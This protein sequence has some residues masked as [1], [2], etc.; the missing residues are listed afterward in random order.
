MPSFP[1]SVHQREGLV[2]VVG[3]ALL[4]EGAGTPL[5]KGQLPVKMGDVADSVLAFQIG[6]GEILLL[7]P[8]T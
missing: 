1:V 6:V 2:A 8:V 3:D 7:A 5:T 4:S